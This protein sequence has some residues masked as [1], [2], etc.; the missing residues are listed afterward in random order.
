[1]SKSITKAD[2]AD[3]A[4]ETALALPGKAVLSAEDFLRAKGRTY[5]GSNILHLAVG[6]AAGPIVITEIGTIEVD[7]PAKK[8][9]KKELPHYRGTC[10]GIEVSLP[11]ATSFLT[12]AEKAGLEPGSK[13]LILRREDYTSSQGRENCQ[14]YS[15]KV[16]E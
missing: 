6:Q 8:G 14:A 12:A 11:I 4:E 5:G 15:I 3:M 13:I 1:M 9:R 10:E 16:I 7:D 2:L